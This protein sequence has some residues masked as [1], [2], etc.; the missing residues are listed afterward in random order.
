MGRGPRTPTRVRGRSRPPRA[1][2]ARALRRR[3]RPRRSPRHRPWTWRPCRPLRRRARRGRPTPTPR[4]TTPRGARRS[5]SPMR[6][7][8]RPRRRRRAPG[9]PP[10]T[11]PDSPCRRTT[12]SRHTDAREPRA[13]RASPKQTRR[14]WLPSRR[15]RVTAAGSH[16][17]RGR[18]SLC[19]PDAKGFFVTHENDEK[20]ASAS[21]QH[22]AAASAP[23]LPGTNA[24][25]RGAS[26]ID[27]SHVRH[28]ESASLAPNG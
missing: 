7:R 13:P 21:E 25:A 11:T 9:A 16:A 26:R 5:A 28:D 14:A 15:W 8:R 23:R 2:V 20:R 6:R 24:R 12:P 4:G 3:R 1:G 22:A 18:P 27:E 10:R 17:T 19:A